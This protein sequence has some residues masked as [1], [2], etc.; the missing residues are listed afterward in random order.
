MREDKGNDPALQREAVREI[1]EIVKERALFRGDF[2]LSSGAKSSYYFDA[3]MVTLWPRGAYLIG[4]AVFDLLKEIP[5]DAVG[6]MTLG[7]DPIVASVAVVSHLEGKPLS[8]F[9]VRSEPKPHGARKYIEGPLPQG[10]KVAIVDDV[11]T[12]GGSIFRAIEAVEAAGCE[13][14]KVICLLDRCQGGSDELRKRG[15][16]FTPILSAD[17]EGEVTVS[18]A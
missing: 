8:A 1:L 5:V 15:Y 17:A 10:G 13:V 6:G 14:V 2:T 11:L 12:T 16:D 9:I 3:R 4:K 7:A 18:Q